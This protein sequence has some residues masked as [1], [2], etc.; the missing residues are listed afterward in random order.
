M[1]KLGMLAIPPLFARGEINEPIEVPLITLAQ[2]RILEHRAERWRKRH[3]EFERHSVI[4]QTLHHT[5]QRNV[6]F[7]DRFEEPVFFEEMLM[8]RMPDEWKMRVEDEGEVTHCR[9]Q[10]SNSRLKATRPKFEIGNLQSA[11]TTFGK[12]LGNGPS[13][14]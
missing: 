9:F 7:R 2:K 8:L 3:R 10:I 12:S 14:F 5:Q 4:H 1:A 13:L 6:T 11:I